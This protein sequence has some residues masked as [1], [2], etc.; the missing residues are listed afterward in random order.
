MREPEVVLLE[1]AVEERAVLADR[2][3]DAAERAD[4]EPAVKPRDLSSGGSEKFADRHG[5]LE[6]RPGAQ[7]LELAHADFA[8]P[9]IEEFQV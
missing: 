8:Q 3:R 6:V 1:Q 2:G 5:A 4:D 9:A 7:E